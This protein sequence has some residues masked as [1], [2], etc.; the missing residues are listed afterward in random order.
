MYPCVRV[1]VPIQIQPF[2]IDSEYG[3][4]SNDWGKFKKTEFVLKYGVLWY[5]LQSTENITEWKASA[6][7]ALIQNWM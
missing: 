3:I 2:N 4:Q 7:E 5:D 6:F 1:C